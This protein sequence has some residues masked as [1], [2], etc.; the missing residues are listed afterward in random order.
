MREIKRLHSYYH[1][2]RP[3]DKFLF[4]K[5]LKT[6]FKDSTSQTLAQYIISHR[7]AI[8]HSVK[9]WK[10]SNENG[11]PSVLDWLASSIKKNEKVVSN[12]HEIQ[13][14]DLMD[15]RQKEKR[16]KHKKKC[17]NI[18]KQKITVYMKSNKTSKETNT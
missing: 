12:L 17:Y 16:R 9:M 7:K 14:K 3:R 18:Q 1:Q 2:V 11:T 10:I 5:D 8:M 13:R 4:Q 6:F 15:G